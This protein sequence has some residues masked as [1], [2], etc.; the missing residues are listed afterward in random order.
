MVRKREAVVQELRSRI[1]AGG[2]QPGSRVPSERALASEF[3]ASR[4]VIQAALADLENQGFLKR[5]PNRRP[6]VNLR[7]PNS[8]I[9]RS[10]KLKQIAIWILPDS[11]DLGGMMILQGIRTAFGEAGYDLTIGCPPS[12]DRK[13]L[14]AAELEFLR[15]LLTDDSI[16]GAILWDGGHPEAPAIHRQLAEKG[17]ATVFIDREPLGGWPVNVVCCNNRRAAASVAAHLL[18]LGHRRLAT[19]VA[20]ESPSSVLERTQTFRDVCAARG[21]QVSEMNIGDPKDRLAGAEAL[22]RQVLSD[23]SGPTALFAVNDRVGLYLLEAANKLQIA[24]PGRLSI[25]G[26]DW[27]LRWTPS[28]GE[29]TTVAQPFEEIGRTAAKRLLDLIGSVHAEPSRHILLEA[30]LVVKGSTGAPPP[31][32]CA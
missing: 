15:G 24:V 27:L 6:T 9:N 8:P 25:V 14:Q 11:Q 20:W 10:K 17:L 31:N 16:G 28:G 5:I 21:A 19:V 26:F 2:L 7:P 18:G 4:I 12:N 32:F 29:L 3:G 23:P 13:T 30:P 22:L 1:V